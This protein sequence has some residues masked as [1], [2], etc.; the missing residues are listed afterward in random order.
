MVQ[1]VALKRPRGGV[2]AGEAVSGPPPPPHSGPFCGA[3]FFSCVLCPQWPLSFD[4]I[5][6]ESCLPRRLCPAPPP[7]RPGRS[8]GP[9]SKGTFRCLGQLGRFLSSGYPAQPALCFA[10]AL[11]SAQAGLAEHPNR[12]LGPK[13]FGISQDQFAA[14]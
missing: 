2:V 7:E 13:S 14:S 12:A 10:D 9:S 8:P 3:P 1:P 6:W 5:V 11:S 4:S